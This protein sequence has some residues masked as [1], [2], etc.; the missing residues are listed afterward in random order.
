MDLETHGSE[1][2]ADNHFLARPFSSG[3]ISE[4]IAKAAADPNVYL[5]QPLRRGLYGM[6][7]LRL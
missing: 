6:F 1:S 7:G 5:Y 2:P 3:T 4:L